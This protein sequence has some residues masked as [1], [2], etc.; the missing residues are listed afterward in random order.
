M[1]RIPCGK[2]QRMHADL[3]HCGHHWHQHQEYI[4]HNDERRHR[5]LVDAIKGRGLEEVETGQL[6]AEL[7]RRGLLPK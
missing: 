6:L 4:T 5:E 3:C 7:H 2:F 1:G